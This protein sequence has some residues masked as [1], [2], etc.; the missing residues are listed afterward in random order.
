MKRFFNN[1]AT[2]VAILAISFTIQ[3]CDA[4]V[5]A[6]MDGDI[7]F[8][9]Q[10]TR[11][12]P[13]PAAPV[14]DVLSPTCDVQTVSYPL[15]AGQ[16]LDAGAVTVDVDGDVL[17]I[18][19]ASSWDV[20]ETHVQISTD[21]PTQRGAPGRYAHNNY[22]SEDGITYVFG[23]S[24]LGFSAGDTFYVLAHAVV[25]DLATGLTETAYAGNIQ[26]G[27][28]AWYGVMGYK[29]EV[30]VCDAP[31]CTANEFPV[32]VQDI[33]HVTLVFENAPGVYRTVKI[34]GW[35][36]VKDLDIKDLNLHID[37]IVTYLIA[38]DAAVNSDS[39]LLGAVIKSGTQVETKFHNYGC[40]NGGLPAGA[41]ITFMNN[42]NDQGA[43]VTYEAVQIL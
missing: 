10:P 25:A 41:G 2:I 12:A 36:G 3:S 42:G 43:Q 7:A 23:L 5:S 28:G 29:V 11:L 14:V 13:A 24:E 9:G 6:D 1:F 40:Y 4:P 39:V 26:T 33:S 22:V 31:V 30:P 18:T 34:D 32:I 8:R 27:K 38:N 20:I 37:T 17:T 16:H 21:V 19:F 35:D 15:V